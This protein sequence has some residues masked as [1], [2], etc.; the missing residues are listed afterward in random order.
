MRHHRSTENASSEISHEI[1]RQVRSLALHRFSEI[2]WPLIFRCPEEFHFNG[3]SESMEFHEMQEGDETEL[4]W[5]AIN[6]R[7]HER[8][9]HSL[10]HGE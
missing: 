9:Y 2:S 3:D 7:N 4:F 10:L 8:R 5:Q 6:E 1:T